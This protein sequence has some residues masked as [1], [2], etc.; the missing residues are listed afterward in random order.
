MTT[1]NT[2]KISKYALPIADMQIGKTYPM[3]G[4]ITKFVQDKIGEVVVEINNSVT[5]NMSISDSESLELLKERA[6]DPGIF[7][8]KV[9]S[10]EPVIMATCDKVIFGKRPMHQ[11]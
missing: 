5:I 2:P 6:F 7:V 8:S 10:L 4:I 1:P 3:Y 9:T 11:H